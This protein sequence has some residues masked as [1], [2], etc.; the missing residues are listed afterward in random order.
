[1]STFESHPRTG[2]TL[3][4]RPVA[5][6]NVMPYLTGLLLVLAM[7]A[8]PIMANGNE[9]SIT[10]PLTRNRSERNAVQTN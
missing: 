7:T 4:Y 2:G 10:T 6:R 1:M 8:Y 9:Q 5:I 3:L